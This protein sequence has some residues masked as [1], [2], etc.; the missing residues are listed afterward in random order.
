MSRD[1]EQDGDVRALRRLLAVPA[2]RD[3]PAGRRIQ[4]EE[5]LMRSLRTM[6]EERTGW[7]GGWVQKRFALGL[8]A[9]AIAAGAIVAV[10]GGAVPGG[11]E[12]EAYAVEKNSDGTLSVYLRDLDWSGDPQH[13]DQ[14]AARIRAAGF[15]AIVDKVPPGKRCRFDR[16]EHLK[17]EKSGDGKW[18]YRYVMTHADAYLVEENLPG[19]ATKGWE[20]AHS[21]RNTFIKGPVKPCDPVS[22]KLPKPS[23]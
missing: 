15:T 22:M 14:L 18:D 10:P 9:A 20:W 16:G 1:R 19:R 11:T 8:A 2:E 4:R 7:R 23:R 13:F 12:S 6:T 17:Q 5:H 21:F 3:L